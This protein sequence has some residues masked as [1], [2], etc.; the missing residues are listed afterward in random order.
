MQHAV[1]A[2]LMRGGTSKGLFVHEA[3]LPPPGP[4]RDAVILRL[5]GS[6][7]P[8][9]I[10]GLGGTYSSTS[11]IVLVA[12]STR[13][14][15]D[16]EYLF[17]QVA[18]DAARVDYAGNCGNLTSAVGPFAIE[19]GLVA[20]EPDSTLVRLLN[21][22]TGKQ[23]H[24][25][26]PTREGR[27]EV[28][29]THRIAGVPGSGARILT[30]YLDPGGAV[31]GAVLPTGHVLDHVEVDGIG[32]VP[33]SIVD[34]AHPYAFVA[35]DSVDIQSDATVAE[36]NADPEVLAR[37]EAVRA[38][39]TVLLCRA[40]SPAAAATESPT[41][42]RLVVV[43][44]PDAW[45][46]PTGDASGGRV[47]LGVKMVSMGRVHH[48]CPITGA[49]CTAAA[50]RIPGTVVSALASHR[51]DQVLRLGHPKGVVEASATVRAGGPDVIVESVTVTRTA[52]RLMAGTA[53]VP[54][55]TLGV[56]P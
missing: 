16:V 8:M 7:D 13:S 53:Y 45:R 11:K 43:E 27:V 12:P 35:S 50:A 17:G 4:S 41:V 24:T 39:C 14:D 47:D 3:D 49:V 6:P 10:D 30:T 21:L 37:L 38:A 29:G 19:E 20:A 1:P 54:T 55:S 42:P 2:V 33:V 52:R 26:V 23:I 40:D 44:P 9:Q 51:G 46:D 48:A 36:L 28:E 25:R 22:N 18:V 32:D 5:M 34:A 31:F 15:C 56:A